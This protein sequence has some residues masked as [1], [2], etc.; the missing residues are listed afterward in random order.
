[1]QHK[2]QRLLLVLFLL[3]IVSTVQAWQI[4]FNGND[5]KPTRDFGVLYTN[6]NNSPMYLNVM[7]YCYDDGSYY[8]IYLLIN[9]SKVNDK[10]EYNQTAY[11]NEM[12]HGFTY[13][14]PSYATYKL[15]RSTDKTCGLDRWLES[16][17]TDDIPTQTIVY[18]NVTNAN[19]LKSIQ[20]T[21]DLNLKY[22]T[23]YNYTIFLNGTYWKEVQKGETILVPD[24]STITIYVPAPISTELSEASTLGKTY[25][26]IAVMYLLVFTA[27]FVIVIYVL[28]KIW[29]Y[30]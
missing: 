26:A 7:F 21:D 23:E 30:K 1:M 17:T 15:E 14:V 13:F 12:Y 29:R 16:N 8:S 24:N 11:P 4:D 9:G 3:T 5:I 28:R 18:Q 6:N 27:A 20:V 10:Y 25:L 2:F 22:L 19:N